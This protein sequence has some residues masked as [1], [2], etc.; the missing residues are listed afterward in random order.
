MLCLWGWGGDACHTAES[1]SFSCGWARKKVPQDTRNFLPFR[2]LRTITD[3]KLHA[4]VTMHSTAKEIQK[5]NRSNLMREENE[6]QIS[7]YYIPH[8]TKSHP[9]QSFKRGFA[10]LVRNKAKMPRIIPKQPFISVPQDKTLILSL[11]PFKRFIL[12]AGSLKP[13]FP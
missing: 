5:H 3:E 11:G 1:Y 7:T 4:S 8:L 13:P 6:L 9:C 2:N 10:V 12:R